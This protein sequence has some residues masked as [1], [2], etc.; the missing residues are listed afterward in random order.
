MRAEHTSAAATG[1]A[2]ALVASTAGLCG[3]LNGLAA[4]MYKRIRQHIQ[5]GKNTTYQRREILACTL[6]QQQHHLKYYQQV[7]TTASTYN[8]KYVQ[9]Q[10]RTTASTYHSKYVL[11]QVRTTAVRTTAST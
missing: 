7:R 5:C 10:V 11:Q 4:A 9:Q 1:V 8:S 3:L 6:Q 2:G